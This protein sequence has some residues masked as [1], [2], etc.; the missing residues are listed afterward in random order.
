MKDKEKWNYFRLFFGII[1]STR[2]TKILVI[3]IK[4]TMP[5]S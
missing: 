1:E 4:G 3:L 5:K 2:V